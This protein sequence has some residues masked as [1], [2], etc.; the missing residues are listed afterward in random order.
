MSAPTAT[1]GDLYLRLQFVSL[2]L[3]GLLRPLAAADLHLRLQIATSAVA[4]ATIITSI[5]SQK[6][7]RESSHQKPSGPPQNSRRA[8]SSSPCASA[9]PSKDIS[10]EDPQMKRKVLR[11]SEL[12]NEIKGKNLMLTESTSNELFE[13]PLKSVDQSK[14]WKIKS[15]Y[16]DIGLTYRDNDAIAYVASR[17]PTVY[18]ACFQ[19]LRKVRRRLLGFSPAKVLDFGAGTEVWPGSLEKVNIME[20]SQSMQHAGQSFIQAEYCLPLVRVG[21]LFVAAKGHDPQVIESGGKNIDVAL[22]TKGDGLKQLEE[23]KIDAIVTE[24][25]VEKAAAEAAKKGPPKKKT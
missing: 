13:D 21:G 14:R 5:P 8:A 19:V 17:L 6:R 1:A 22:M 7:L 18:S 25:E 4:N 10:E 16:G 24:I 12:F 20:P 11:L 23:A 3:P 9:V 15:S 2:W